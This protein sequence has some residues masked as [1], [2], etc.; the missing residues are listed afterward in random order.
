MVLILNFLFKVQEFYLD[1]WVNIPLL[2][3]GTTCKGN[4]VAIGAELLSRFFLA[5]PLRVYC[6]KIV[7]FGN[8]MVLGPTVITDIPVVGVERGTSTSLTQPRGAVNVVFVLLLK[9]HQSLLRPLVLVL[10]RQN[11]FART[12]LWSFQI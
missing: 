11:L 4:D 6:V 2:F 9:S 7:R 5:K 8:A 12:L 1:L 3:Q 10:L